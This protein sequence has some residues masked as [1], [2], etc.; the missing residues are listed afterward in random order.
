MKYLKSL[1][2]NH[3]TSYQSISINL[4]KSDCWH[5][6]LLSAIYSFS[7]YL[8]VLH[9][10]RSCWCFSSWS[11]WLPILWA[12]DG[13]RTCW[14]RFVVCI[15]SGMW[16]VMA[17]YGICYTLLVGSPH[18]Q[19]RPALPLFF[20]GRRKGA[21]PFYNYTTSYIDYNYHSMGTVT[22]TSSSQ[23]VCLFFWSVYVYIYI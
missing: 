20:W 16:I 18:V 10:L 15:A 14:S 4:S 7:N 8:T 17:L 22:I 3:L 19:H 2:S 21:W 5:L 13:K 12:K 23:V 9:P 11:V 1:P 6:P